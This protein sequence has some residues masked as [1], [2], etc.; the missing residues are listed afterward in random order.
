MQLTHKKAT[1]QG[2]HAEESL[3]L[4]SATREAE[5]TNTI[6]DLEGELKHARQQLDRLQTEHDRLTG[7]NSE[8]TQQVRVT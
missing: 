2:I 5:F 8:L 4:E 7:I 1:H 3:L 6:S